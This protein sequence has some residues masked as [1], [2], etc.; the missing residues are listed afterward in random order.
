MAPALPR[1]LSTSLDKIARSAIGKDWNLY[2]ALLEHWRE[3]VG[4]DYAQSASPVKIAF[5][6]GKRPDEKWA[7]KRADGTLY[8][9]LPQGLAME[10]G[11]HAET[12]RARINGFFGYEAIGRIVLET[13]YPEGRPA[14]RE[15][16]P[17]LSAE[18]KARLEQETEGIENDELR[19][20]LQELGESVA[21][22]GI[23]N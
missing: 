14:P 19:E 23:Q 11:F 2:A 8:I 1:A 22:R 4:Q 7:D 12:I 5:P 18:A 3:I 20:V 15:E 6:R 16:P 21:N 9:R 10:F 17:P 13:Y